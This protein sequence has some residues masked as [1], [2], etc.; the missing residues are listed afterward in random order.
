MV[1]AEASGGP[2]NVSWLVSRAEGR[3][4]RLRVGR[5]RGGRE[6]LPLDGPR[7]LAGRIHRPCHRGGVLPRRKV[8]RP[9]VRD[10]AVAAGRGGGDHRP[11]VASGGAGSGFPRS[12]SAPG[13]PI[14]AGFDLELTDYTTTLTWDFDHVLGF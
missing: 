10:R 12:R 4:H 5:P 7:A 2:A 1:R 11:A 9:V 14:P 3:A 13:L 8:E 6:Q